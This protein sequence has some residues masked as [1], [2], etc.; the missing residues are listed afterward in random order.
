M[1]IQVNYEEIIFKNMLYNYMRLLDEVTLLAV[2]QK[3]ILNELLTNNPHET[4]SC[5]K[6]KKINRIPLWKTKQN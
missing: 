3:V 6:H 4:V 1:A 5:G 2:Y